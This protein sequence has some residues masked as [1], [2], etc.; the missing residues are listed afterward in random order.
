M[1]IPSDKRASYL[2]YATQAGQQTDAICLAAA[3]HRFG[4]STCTGYHWPIEIDVL[5]IASRQSGLFYPTAT[6]R[7]I[8]NFFSAFFPSLFKYYYWPFFLKYA[9]HRILSGVLGEK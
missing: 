1:S 8:F 3:G 9:G 2:S 6:T 4:Q 5:L 7:R